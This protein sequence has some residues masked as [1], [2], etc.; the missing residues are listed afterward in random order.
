MNATGSDVSPGQT[1]NQDQD[2]EEKA[3]QTTSVVR[4]RIRLMH[5]ELFKHTLTTIVRNRQQNKKYR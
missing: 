5:L 1:P 3:Q 4:P 2:L